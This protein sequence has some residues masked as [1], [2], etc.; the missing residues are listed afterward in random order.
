MSFILYTWFTISQLDCDK[1]NY[2]NF[3]HHHNAVQ[4][5]IFILVSNKILLPW[6]FFI[7]INWKWDKKWI[8]R[9]PYNCV[10]LLFLLRRLA[11]Q[12]ALAP[13]MSPDNFGGPALHKVYLFWR[14]LMEKNIPMNQF[15][16]NTLILALAKGM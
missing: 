4:I 8:I 12:K 1:V 7:N 15:T 9:F 14:R 10:Y 13:D 16:Y 6:A 5:F 11:L 3:Y 2:L